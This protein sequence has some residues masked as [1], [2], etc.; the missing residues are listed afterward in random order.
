MSV[1][2]KLYQERGTL[3]GIRGT[4]QDVVSNI[5]FVNDNGPESTLYDL[6]P[7]RRPTGEP[8]TYSYHMFNYFQ[9]TGTHNG[10]TRPRIVISGG[11]GA[12]S[13][14]VYTSKARLYYRLTEFYNTPD[15]SFNGELIYFDGNT[16]RM[17]PKTSSTGPTE[18]L[19]YNPVIVANQPVYTMLLET[20]LLVEINDPT[21]P[22]HDNDYTLPGGLF[23]YG[24][25]AGAQV[26]FEIDEF[27]EVNY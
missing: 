26:K 18:G 25:F 16:V 27:E 11:S 6:N 13:S 22:A 10:L 4:I 2:I 15:A 3:T 19:A 21:N 23:A 20:Q 5:G 24:N 9:V 12:G 7:I 17:V 1:S 8:F 14:Y